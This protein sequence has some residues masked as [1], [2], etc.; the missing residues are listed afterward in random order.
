M[1]PDGKFYAEAI[2]KECGEQYSICKCGV[3][4]KLDQLLGPTVNVGKR[5]CIRH[6][7]RE[8]FGIDGCFCLECLRE[9][10]KSDK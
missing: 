6:P 3:K 8:A 10:Q 5:Y 4:R 9:M 2:C 7:L 1:T